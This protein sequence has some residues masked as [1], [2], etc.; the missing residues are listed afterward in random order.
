MDRPTVGGVITLNQMSQFVRMLGYVI[1]SG[2]SR[3]LSCG[4]QQGPKCRAVRP[5]GPK[6]GCGFW[7]GA[8]NPLEGLVEREAP[9]TQ[10]FSCILSALDGASCCIL[11]A[12]CT[13]K[14]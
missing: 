9:V 12:F 1:S 2:V 3:I 5:E 14:L 6:P 7:G 10:R 11:R 4:I 8:A 13:K